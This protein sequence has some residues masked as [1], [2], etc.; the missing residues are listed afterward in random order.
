[1]FLQFTAFIKGLDD[2]TEGTPRP[3]VGG[4]SVSELECKAVVKND[5]EKCSH[6]ARGSSNLRVGKQAGASLQQNKL[7]PRRKE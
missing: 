1:M 4:T 6:T 5:L 3:F 2:G 7:E